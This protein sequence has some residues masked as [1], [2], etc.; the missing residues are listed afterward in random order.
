M[1]IYEEAKTL[2][3]TDE[4]KKDLEWILTYAG[5][6][7]YATDVHVPGGF[8]DEINNFVKEMTDEKDVNSHL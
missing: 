8:A 6:D 5:Y 4:E 1:A 7:K 3:T 2:A